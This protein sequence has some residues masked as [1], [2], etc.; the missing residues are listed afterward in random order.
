VINK[1]PLIIIINTS[2]LFYPR[3]NEYIPYYSEKDIVLL[4]DNLADALENV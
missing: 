2:C 4:C 1:T 3:K